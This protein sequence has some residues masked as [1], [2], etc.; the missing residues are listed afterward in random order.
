MSNCGGY[1]QIQSHLLYSIILLLYFSVPLGGNKE[2]EYFLG[3]IN[4]LFLGTESIILMTTETQPV[5][6]SIEIPEFDYY[7]SGI[8]VNKEVIV[9][10]PSGVAY[11]YN[12]EQKGIYVIA[13]STK[14][15]VVGQ[16]VR[17]SVSDTFLALPNYKLQL[18]R[19][20]YYGFL[21]PGITNMANTRQ[22]VV[23]TE[24]NTQLNI[25]VLTLLPVIFGGNRTLLHPGR[26]YSFVIN[27][28]QTLRTD[29]MGIPQ[30][31]GIK[32]VTNK[33]VS[34]FIGHPC[35]SI[36]HIFSRRGSCD[37]LI[38]Q[39]PPTVFWGREYYIAPF[40]SKRLYT[41][42]IVAAYDLTNVFLYC[43]NTEELYVVNQGEF[44]NK[45]IL[46]QEYCAIYSN[47]QV[48]VTQLSHRS[49][50]DNGIGDPMMTLIPATNHYSNMF[51]F[52]TIRNPMK[53]GYNHYV[54]IAVLA[55]YYQPWMIYLKVGGTSRSLS[56]QRWIPI[57]VDNI[58][59][60]YITRV[61]ITEGMAEIMHTNPT[62]LMTV[63]VYGF[64]HSVGYGHPGGFVPG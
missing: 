56:R 57:E 28:L 36:E 42:T 61:N 6:Y 31:Y 2:N 3:F 16:S 40:A 18:K 50:E 41:V 5:H 64:A 63:I 32:I 24:N 39:I 45:T 17:S 47:K 37:Y 52:S 54:S 14:M 49:S 34:F 10:L 59:K 4:Q 53:S 44:L 35:A 9:N 15:T 22:V 7:S 29:N 60:A 11:R 27:R 23:G 38:E 33:P 8:I 43:N 46:H 58:T 62:A 25:T 26:Q 12:D 55:Q 19:Y 30:L 1:L 13:N 51:Q 21:L 48:L 20:E